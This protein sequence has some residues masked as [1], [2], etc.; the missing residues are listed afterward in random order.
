MQQEEATTSASP[1]SML[2]GATY[3]VRRAARAGAGRKRG[4]EQGRESK[5]F[6]SFFLAMPFVSISRGPLE[7]CGLPSSC[8]S[9]I[10][11]RQAFFRS[12]RRRQSG[13]L[14]LYALTPE[15]RERHRELNWKQKAERK[16]RERAS[17]RLSSAR[18]VSR[19]PSRDLLS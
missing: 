3:K 9:P 11:P 14:M 18:R 16:L 17:S 6:L 1:W 2:R 12:L 15:S 7:T 10:P 13:A 5:F 19:P 8:G 4:T